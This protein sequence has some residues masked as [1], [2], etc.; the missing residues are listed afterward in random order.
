MQK[1]EGSDTRNIYIYV[2]RHILMIKK[3]DETFGRTR[4]KRARGKSL[5]FART[6]KNGSCEIIKGKEEE[7]EISPS[8]GPFYPC[9]RAGLRKGLAL[10]IQGDVGVTLAK[11]VKRVATIIP[12]VG[13]G[14]IHDL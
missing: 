5:W 8:V 3:S 14:R 2:H 6:C 13:L 4:M 9:G 11:V 7:E 12:A 10:E 1:Y